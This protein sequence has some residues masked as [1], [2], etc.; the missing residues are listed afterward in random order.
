MSIEAQ[1]LYGPAEVCSGGFR[2]LAT[3]LWLGNVNSHYNSRQVVSVSNDIPH[4]V[5]L[6]GIGLEVDGVRQGA[7][8]FPELLFDDEFAVRRYMASKVRG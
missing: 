2:P 8:P 3:T 4:I 7:V 5:C 1:S 6:T